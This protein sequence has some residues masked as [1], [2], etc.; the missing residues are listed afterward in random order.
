M[1]Y[2]APYIP[3]QTN[4]LAS[5]PCRTATRP[6]EHHPR[7]TNHGRPMERVQYRRSIFFLK[8]HFVL[9]GSSQT[10]EG[11]SPFLPTCH[12]EKTYHFVKSRVFRWYFFIP[13]A[14]VPTTRAVWRGRRG[15]LT[16]RQRRLSFGDRFVLFS[17]SFFPVF[18]EGVGGLLTVT[19]RKQCIIW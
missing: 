2:I 13:S 8:K 18:F 10:V 9:V 11:R 14:S 3:P 17:H 19:V 6:S 7:K 15:V 12:Q 16:D 5:K 1:P 4:S